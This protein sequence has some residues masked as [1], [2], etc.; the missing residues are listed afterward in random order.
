MTPHEDFDVDILNDQGKV[1]GVKKR[2]DV[3]KQH[4]V[5]HSVFV[6]VVTP[7][8][9]VILAAIPV[10]PEQHRWYAGCLGS[11]AAT[12]VRHGEPIDVAAR[13][14]L[15]HE[16]FLDYDEPVFLGEDFETY[17]DGIQKLSTTYYSVHNGE[18]KPNP[19]EQDR[20]VPL[21]RAQIEAM[22]KKDPSVFAP[23]FLALW[24]R[25]GDRLPV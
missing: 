6:L 1:V 14:V 11:T 21:S 2:K 15:A 9:E 22:I 20:L 23:T 25:Y 16:L 12:I 24:R 4:D 17:P 10:A 5:L 13:R 19:H 7:D 18:L 3:D 8:R